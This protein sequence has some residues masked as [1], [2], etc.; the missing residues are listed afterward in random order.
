MVVVVKTKIK[1][2][3]PQIFRV[4]LILYKA[5]IVLLI[6]AFRKAINGRHQ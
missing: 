1:V 4:V 2:M 5:L 3:V 6:R